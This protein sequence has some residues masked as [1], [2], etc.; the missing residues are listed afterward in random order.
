MIKMLSNN[1]IVI[2]IIIIMVGVLIIIIGSLF[3]A[4]GE[5]KWGF[6][7]FIFPF[8]FGFANDPRLLW[9]VLIITLILLIIFVFP[10]LRGLI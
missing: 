6:G 7:G 3:A 5:T 2:G 1:L 4:K 9:I 10:I 8:F